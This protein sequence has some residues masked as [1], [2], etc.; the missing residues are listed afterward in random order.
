MS[1]RIFVYIILIPLILLQGCTKL[2]NSVQGTNNNTKIADTKI[3]SEAGMNQTDHKRAELDSTVIST[4]DN[5]AGQ[6]TNNSIRPTNDTGE[7]MVQNKL[8]LEQIEESCAKAN[9]E[10]ISTRK[11]GDYIIVESHPLNSSIII[12]LYNLKTGDKDMLPSCEYRIDSDKTY[13]VNENDI[14]LYSSGKNYVC[15][16]QSFPLQIHCKRDSENIGSNSDFMPYLEDVKLPVTQ[17]ISLNGKPNVKQEITDIRVTVN[18]LQICFGP[19]DSEDILYI[20]D[21]V[22]C[23]PT[24]ISYDETC[25]E[26]TLKFKDTRFAQS[27]ANISS[28]P[29]SNSY[30]K[31]IDLKE[32]SDSAS[33]IIKLNGSAKYFTGKKSEVDFDMLNSVGIPYM[34]IQFFNSNK[35]F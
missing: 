21:Y 34:D 11:Y 15:G 16:Y 32:S 12:T 25:K 18:G 33:V 9:E 1:K 27:Y 10:I 8:T 6:D 4:Q 20:A 29:Y 31:F 19:Q 17:Q 22:D 24:S 14:I 30:I 28:L 26:F 7:N 2:D 3:S 23:P 5:A 13:W 35:K